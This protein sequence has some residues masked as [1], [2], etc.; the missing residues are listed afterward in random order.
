MYL[1]SCI[2]CCTIMMVLY[3][4]DVYYILRFV[5]AKEVKWGRE[6]H[7]EMKEGSS[8]FCSDAIIA[9]RIISN[10]TEEIRGNQIDQNKQVE[11]DILEE[12]ILSEKSVFLV[13]VTFKYSEWYCWAC[14]NVWIENILVAIINICPRTVHCILCTLFVVLFP[15]INICP[16][17]DSFCLMT[18]THKRLNGCH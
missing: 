7:Y 9:K 15:N 4:W 16:G 10:R 1:L 6:S 8:F 5:L 17:D 2:R 11:L 3:A 18:A 14:S 12:S 13:L